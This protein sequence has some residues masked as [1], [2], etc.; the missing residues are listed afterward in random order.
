MLSI[1]EK[2]CLPRAPLSRR[3]VL[4]LAALTL[5]PLT[6]ACYPEKREPAETVSAGLV[7]AGPTDVPEPAGPS[8][9]TMTGERPPPTFTLAPT[10]TKPP[11]ATAFR[12]SATAIISTATSDELRN[13]L[14]GEVVADPSLLQRRPLAVKVSNAP[15]R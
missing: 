9:Q 8:G 3:A 14:T 7:T 2:N 15:A 1:R 11:T 5:K 12:Q 10:E 4:F 13:P 6:S